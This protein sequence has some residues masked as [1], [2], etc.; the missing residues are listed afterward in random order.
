MRYKIKDLNKKNKAPISITLIIIWIV[1]AGISTLLKQFD[2][3]RLELNKQILGSSLGILN[4]FADWVIFGLFIFFL[5]LFL[6][7]KPRTVMYFNYFIILQMIGLI[8]SL[9]FSINH[10]QEIV[11]AYS[12][13]SV[14]HMFYILAFVIVILI[15]LFVYSLIIYFTNKNKKYF[16]K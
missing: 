4:Y 8:I 10:V 14:P 13:P 1:L 5:I 11:D 6:K 3:S 16:N 7:R 12:Q 15:Q 2:M 9:F